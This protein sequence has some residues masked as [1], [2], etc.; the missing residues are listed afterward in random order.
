MSKF[1]CFIF[2][3]MILVNQSKAGDQIPVVSSLYLQNYYLSSE[4]YE[5]T[6]LKQSNYLKGEMESYFDESG[7]F[8]DW[9][10]RTIAVGLGAKLEIGIADLTFGVIPKFRLVFCKKGLKPIFP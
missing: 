10:L 9:N 6:L 8:Q 2:L 3:G 5:S 7:I 4:E 1:K